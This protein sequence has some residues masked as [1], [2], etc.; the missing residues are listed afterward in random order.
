MKWIQEETKFE[1]KALSSLYFSA[2]IVLFAVEFLQ[3]DPFSKLIDFFIIASVNIARDNLG[4]STPW[5]LIYLIV[6]GLVVLVK[7][8]ILDPLGI[9]ADGDFKTTWAKWVMLVLVLGQIAFYTNQLFCALGPMPIW[10]P[11]WIAE[12]LN[13]NISFGAVGETGCRVAKSYKGGEI[14]KLI[15]PAIWNLGPLAF[16]MYSKKKGE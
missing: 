4:L 7:R 15:I 11:E 16:L 6:I 12:L 3:F 2:I 8:T 13:G 14:W 1:R 5:V 9:G 10:V